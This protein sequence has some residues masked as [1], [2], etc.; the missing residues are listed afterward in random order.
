M[1][2][3]KRGLNL[4]NL[5]PAILTL[6]LVGLMLGVGLYML[7]ELRLGI[8]TDKTGTD[9]DVLANGTTRTTNASTLSDA[10]ATGYNLVSID[11]I[12]VAT[13]GSTIPTANYTTGADGTITF[14]AETA[15]S[16]W[17]INITSTFNS[18]A[19]DSPEESITTSLT[20]LA[21]FADWI[22]LIVVVLAAAVVLGV[23]LSSFGREPGV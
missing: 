15:I 6:I 5:Y 8:A 18:D 17:Y 10:T 16:D 22:T 21:T 11:T 23:V 2:Q 13:D 20:G 14:T 4:G 19:T 12:I 7:Q 9:D 1:I 3:D